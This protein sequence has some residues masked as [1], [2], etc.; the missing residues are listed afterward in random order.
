MIFPQSGFRLH[1]ASKKNLSLLM[2]LQLEL[3]G[4]LVMAFQSYS[5]HMMSSL[6]M[7]RELSVT[8]MTELPVMGSWCPFHL[9]CNV[10]EAEVC[11]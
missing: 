5:V 1:G 7:M 9:G 10:L 4:A 8:E 11:V 2:A 3:E 6:D